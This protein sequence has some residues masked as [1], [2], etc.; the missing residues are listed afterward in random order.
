MTYPGNKHSIENAEHVVYG[1]RV[2]HTHK[3]RM[4]TAVLKYS[5]HLKRE[6]LMFHTLLDVA[7][8]VTSRKQ[9]EI[10]TIAYDI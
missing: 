4:G 10:S 2:F 6:Y 9:F 7:L 8:T 5:L 1:R 3:L